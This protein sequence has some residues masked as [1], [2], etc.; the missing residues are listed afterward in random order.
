M[1]LEEVLRALGTGSMA[2]IAQERSEAERTA[3]ASFIT[4]K[5]AEAPPGSTDISGHCAANAQ[6]R[7]L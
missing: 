4:G 6:C 2:S 7:Q 1:K 5:G 3:I